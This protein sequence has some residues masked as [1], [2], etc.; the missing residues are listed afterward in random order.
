[1]DRFVIRG[2][3][4]AAEPAATT[5]AAP[6]AVSVAGTKRKHE[7]DGVQKGLAD[8]IVEAIRRTEH[9]ERGRP[10]TTVEMKMSE[11]D[12]KALLRGSP[13]GAKKITYSNAASI[14]EWLPSLPSTIKDVTN[15]VATYCGPGDDGSVYAWAGYESLD[16]AFNKSSGSLKVKVRTLLVGYG[17]QDSDA[18]FDGYLAC[19]TLPELRK[20]IEEKEF[21]DDFGGDA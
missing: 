17:L 2:K 1:M 16:V 10:F 19:K 3:A 4:P 9:T 8:R 5:E 11:A 6:A 18:H 15:R 14:L 13:A 7:S 12:A 20:W 21:D